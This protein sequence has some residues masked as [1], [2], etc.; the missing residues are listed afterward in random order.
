M[1]QRLMQSLLRGMLGLG[2]FG[3]TFGLVRWNRSAPAE[4]PPDMVWVLGGEF[5]MG[6]DSDLG[7]PDEKPAHR[8]RVDGF[9]MDQAEVTNAQFR[10]FV[11]ATGY[12][13]TA[14]KPPDLDEI[15]S[16]V[17]PGTPSPSKEKLVAGALL[18]TPPAGPVR[19]DDFS[20]W[21]KWTPG[22]SLRH[23]EGPAVTSRAARTTPWSRSPGLRAA[24]GCGGERAERAGQPI[25]E[26]S[27]VRVEKPHEGTEGRAAGRG[28][29]VG[30]ARRMRSQRFSQM[31]R[32]RRRRE[33]VSRGRATSVR[34]G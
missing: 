19:L 23:P 18:F 9:W 16:Q 15:M 2:A 22:A 10:A 33:G 21:W 26:L 32:G 4:V 11:E 27:L 5:T 17:P 25:G 14:E 29:N 7:W 13:T 12:V 1:N 6:T 24:A 8:V 31:Q 28:R 3:V 34:D 30:G 20:Q